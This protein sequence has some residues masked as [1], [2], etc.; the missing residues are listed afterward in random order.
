MGV[1][2]APRFAV[3]WKTRGTLRVPPPRIGG[4]G[5]S[6]LPYPDPMPS[7]A[8]PSD[9]AE[10]LFGAF[11]AAHED[12]GT[13]DVEELIAAHPELTRELEALIAEWR[14]LA[15]LRGRLAERGQG[16]DPAE[17]FARPPFGPGAEPP[18]DVL[19]ALQGREAAVE[20]YRFRGEI[21]RGGMGIVLRVRD[22]DLRRE[23]AM[24]VLRRGTGASGTPPASASRS[25]GRFLEE[26]Q[27]TGQLDHPAI[28][29]VHE[30]GLDAK[31][32]PYFTMKLVRGRDLTHVF[33]SVAEGSEGWTLPRALGVLLQ[34]CEAMAYAHARGVVHRDLKPGNIM[35]GDFG[36]V[37]VVDWGLAR[38]FG[39]ADAGDGAERADAV[40]ARTPIDV[41][42]LRAAQ[43]GT[44]SDGGLETLEGEVVGT[45]AY[46]P[47]EQ[48]AGARSELGPAVDVYAVGA[49][50]H[51]LLT[52]RVPHAADGARAEVV[53][54]RVRTNPVPAISKLA[55]EAP[56]EL[57]SIAEKAM[58]R[59]ASARY[60]SMQALAD[61]LRAFLEGR[62][63]RAYETGALAE[64]RKWVRR[65][66]PLA[67]ALAAGLAIA[68]VGLGLALR[69]QSQARAR[70]AA[71]RVAAQESEALAV[72]R[73]QEASDERASAE[74]VVDFLVD[75]FRSSDPSRTRGAE[76]SA[77]ELLGRGAARIAGRRGAHADRT[78]APARSDRARPR[79]TRPTRRRPTV[80]GRE[81]G[82]L[83]RARRLGRPRATDRDRAAA[84]QRRGPARR[85][86]RAGG[87][88]RTP[89]GGRVHARA[90]APDDAGRTPHA[91]R[92]VAGPGHAGGR[93]ARTRPARG[94]RRGASQV[95]G[96]ARVAGPDP[97][98]RRPDRSRRRGRARLARATRSDPREG[99]SAHDPRT[100]P[101]GRRPPEGARADRGG[102]AVRGAVG[103]LPA[104]LPPRPRVDRNGDGQ[105]GAGLRWAG[106]APG[107]GAPS[108]RGPRGAG[109]GP[110][111]R[112]P[113][114]ARQ[115][116]QPLDALLARGPGGG[117]ARARDRR[118]R[119]RTRAP[120]RAPPPRRQR[121][122]QPGHPQ[123]GT[124]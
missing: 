49:M 56:V 89:R 57:V 37:Y 5:V 117:R 26:A 17:G 50:L 97:A 101:P 9:R 7:P 63:V 25:L 115:P 105:P 107:R 60:P 19:A 39:N 27:I 95:P 20:R 79:R 111:R 108:F 43:D 75:L 38:V 29:P 35:V 11:L 28:A 114:R 119:D 59:D 16:D 54:H 76:P 64:L 52:G 33:A 74:R 80:P 48:A 53:L 62:V 104:H 47:P 123:R 102:T 92:F 31:G 34:V 86:L 24:K 66:R 124:G 84:A 72:A 78:C 46:M 106:P 15:S 18:A 112:T 21:G 22:D 44:D 71:A 103:T 121:E 4:P 67:A 98:R 6:F 10:E 81:R 100:E 77:S 88:A 30:V 93:R 87:A 13:P 96:V 65:N 113:P 83:E 118:L 61:D 82:D 40:D 58:E 42:G 69:I 3:G 70:E 12:G 73:A 90:P 2:G 85:G 122:V 1:D 41:T 120:R 14:G 55:P 99:P 116:A 91:P 32:D 45:P 94:L 51:H 8:S 110:G 36:A 109:G 68:F 23:L